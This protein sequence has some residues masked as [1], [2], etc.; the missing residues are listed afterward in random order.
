LRHSL[1]DAG[2]AELSLSRQLDNRGRL[3]FGP[4]ASQFQRKLNR[5]TR[6]FPIGWPS[7]RSSTS[8]AAT[9]SK[10]AAAQ[11]TKSTLFPKTLFNVRRRR[12]SSPAP[13][14]TSASSA[15]RTCAKTL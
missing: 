10:F 4:T 9:G 1:T 15:N 2:V 7:E 3:S 14:S 11:T 6:P 13:F 8:I 5:R 12:R